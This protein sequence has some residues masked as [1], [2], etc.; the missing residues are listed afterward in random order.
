[1]KN[2]VILY[3]SSS[4]TTEEIAKLIAQKINTN[5]VFDVANFPAADINNYDNLIFW[6]FYSRHW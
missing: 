6:F 1:M 3:G 4:G 2:T 5:N